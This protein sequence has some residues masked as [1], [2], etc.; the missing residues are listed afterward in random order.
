MSAKFNKKMDN[1]NR[2]E[3]YSAEVKE[4][5]WRSSDEIDIELMPKNA[6]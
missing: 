1:L 2:T 4:V 3:L 6:D 5:K